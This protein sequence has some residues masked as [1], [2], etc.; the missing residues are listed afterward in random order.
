MT[1]FYSPELERHPFGILVPLVVF[2]IPI[3]DA[4]SVIFHRFRQRANIFKGDHRH[5][6]H[7]LARL[8]LSRTSTVLT[9]YLAT[10][11]TALPAII[12]PLLNWTSAVVWSAL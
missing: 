10:T 2:A 9:I 7:R 12:I 11:A 4:F 3:Y 5:F 6:S 8:G 1:T